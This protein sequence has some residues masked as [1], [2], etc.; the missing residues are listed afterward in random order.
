MP[1]TVRCKVIV[2]LVLLITRPPKN[3]TCYVCVYLNPCTCPFNDVFHNAL[4][5]NQRRDSNLLP[6]AHVNCLQSLRTY[7]VQPHQIILVR[8][9]CLATAALA[10]LDIATTIF[11]G[12]SQITVLRKGIFYR[13]RRVDP[14]AF[15]SIIRGGET[16]FSDSQIPFINHCQGL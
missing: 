1:L 7:H 2:L 4:I 13:V 8:T 5:I 15:L 14:F 9:S 10:I 11:Y 16:R 6:Q 12:P 3:W